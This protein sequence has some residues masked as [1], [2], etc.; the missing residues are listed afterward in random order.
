MKH[1]GGNFQSNCTKCHN[2]RN[3]E[4]AVFTFWT[5]A[6]HDNSRRRLFAS[7]GGASNV[8]GNDSYFC[9]GCHTGAVAGTDYY[10]TQAMSL[11]AKSIQSVFTKTFSH[12][13]NSNPGI[14]RP[15]EEGRVANNGTLSGANRHVSC[16][17]CHNPHAAKPIAAGLT[18][19]SV[20]GYATGTPDSLT[21]SAETGW[22]TNQWTGYTLR[23]TEGTGAGQESVIYGNTNAGVVYV[24]FS[25]APVAGS[26][27]IIYG[28]GTPF[29]G[30][31]IRNSQLSVWGINP[32]WPAQPSPPAW[33]DNNGVN[34]S[35]T[36]VPDPIT[37]Q[38]NAVATW[39]RTENA[40]VQGQICIK[41]HSA[42]AYGTTL[43]NYPLSPSGLP[44]SS[45]GT[46]PPTAGSLTMHESDVANDF[47]PNNL[48]Y[49]PIFARG[50]NQPI[51]ANYNNTGLSSVTNP[52]WPK[53]TGTM[54]LTSG[55]VTFSATLPKSVLPGWFVWVSSTTP[56]TTSTAGT[57]TSGF[58]E[59]VKVTGTNTFT[60]R[61]ETG[62]TWP[63][64]TYGTP[65]N[66]GTAVSCAITPGLGAAFA[67]PWGPWS[68]MR[69]TD[70]H[71]SDTTTDPL[72]P[73]GSANKYQLKKG[74]AQTFM[75]I[76]SSGVDTVITGAA[77]DSFH[78]CVNCHRYD[79]YGGPA[80]TSP[81]N[82]TLSRQPHPVD[83]ST[84]DSLTT[85]TLWGTVCQNC[86]GGA[87]VG[88]IHGSNL[89]LGTGRNGTGASNSGQR[90][91]A[92]AY[93]TGVTRST[94]SNGS[95]YVKGAKD[96]VSNCSNTNGG[97]FGGGTVTYNY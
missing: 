47:N 52:N 15:V 25:T 17:D 90:L 34:G 22:T 5:T 95:C 41:C 59:I 26:K 91:L 44:N 19:G 9:Y 54:T 39:N 10:K 80:V 79:V 56:P 68:L 93:W 77:P 92:G 67:A 88:E 21:D 30:N 13:V 31:L 23:I 33:N 38:F 49:H 8:D 72:G 43:A 27:Y 76:N 81:A 84:A 53:V 28:K 69:C 71:E 78:F 64:P 7:I 58:M 97:S 65:A 87:R 50:K 96:T 4:V 24:K 3:G 11:A 40:T 42:Y 29:D 62:G 57:T 94:T 55:T 2:G 6:N 61:V 83:R 74:T 63:N 51:R 66:I 75:T 16:D 12:P 86:H 32:T 89:G 48:G 70:C 14:H 35:T 36:A 82:A 20:T 60:V 1:D 45:G 37:T 18:A 73:H 85:R 46:Y